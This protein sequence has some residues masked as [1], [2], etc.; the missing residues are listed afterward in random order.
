MFGAIFRVAALDYICCVQIINFPLHENN[1]IFTKATL[2]HEN[3]HTTDE[4]ARLH[5]W[6]H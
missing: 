6:Y 3:T 5:Q 2:L 1:M 4:G